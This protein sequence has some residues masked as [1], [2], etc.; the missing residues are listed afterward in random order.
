MT[1]DELNRLFALHVAQTHKEVPLVRGDKSRG[2]ITRYEA[3]T[4]KRP[5]AQAYTPSVIS[6]KDGNFGGDLWPRYTTDANAVLP[7]LEKF[8]WDSTYG[9][10]GQATYRIRIFRRLDAEPH[11]FGEAEAPTFARAAVL[12]LLRSRGVEV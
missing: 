4:V 10:S 6:F 5:G 3:E 2:I 7:W 12:A 9:E 8:V 1:D 11:D